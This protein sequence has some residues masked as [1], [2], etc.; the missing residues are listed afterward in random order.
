MTRNILH[1]E[2][3]GKSFY[4]VPVL[5]DISF[6]VPEGPS[7]DSLGERRGQKHADEYS[8]RCRRGGRRKHGALLAKSTRRRVRR[9]QRAHRIAFIHQELNLF[10]NLSIAEN[11]FVAGFPRRRVAGFR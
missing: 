7:S 4:G 6:D 11:I 9:T 10:T 2:G 8:R 3:I 1:F 5:T